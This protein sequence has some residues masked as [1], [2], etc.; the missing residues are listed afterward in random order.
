MA[1]PNMSAPFF[2]DIVAVS[3]EMHDKQKQ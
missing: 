1:A 2:A 3:R